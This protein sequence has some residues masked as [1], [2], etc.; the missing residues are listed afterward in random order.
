[1]NPRLVA[2][3]LT[4]GLGGCTLIPSGSPTGREFR[5]GLAPEDHPGIVIVELDARVAKAMAAHTR[6]GLATLGPDS[7]KPTLVLKPGDVIATTVYEVSAIPLFGATPGLESGATKGQSIGGHTSTLP[8]QTVEQDGSVP[9][10]FGGTVRI[11]GLTP[12]QA[13]RAISKALE[14]KAT[15]PQVVVSLVSS[16]VNTASVNGDVNRPGMVPITIRGERVLDVVAA[17]GGPHD[18]IFDTD[19]ELI[20]E[21]RVARANLQQVVTDPNQ[22]LHVRPGDSLVLIRN[23]RTFTV[24]GSALKVAQ[25]EFSVEKVSLAEGVARS[26]GLVDSVADVGDIFLLRF[27]PLDVVRSLVPA[28]DEQLTH[29]DRGR[30]LVPVAYHLDLRGASGYFVSQLVQL[31]DKD[32]LLFANAESVQLSKVIAILRGIGGIYYDFRGA[33]TTTTS[34]RRGITT[35]TSGGG[36]EGSE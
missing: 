2:A 17:A 13:G 21:G 1:M 16:A 34:T 27:E 4:I 33:Q 28:N 29:L 14:G 35:T 12:A 18:P 6:P 7:Y 32:V 15:N 23:P 19:V 30:P 26:G 5:G 10:P 25:V 24:L 36:S 31:Q 22:N 3:L 20:R 11:S 9:I 8:S